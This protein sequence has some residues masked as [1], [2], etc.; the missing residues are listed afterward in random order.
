MHLMPPLR[1]VTVPADRASAS[2]VSFAASAAARS[3]CARTSAGRSSCDIYQG[4]MK[5]HPAI[6]LAMSMLVNTGSPHNKMSCLG[7]LRITR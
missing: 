1:C 6:R 4:Q 2:A 3:A 5:R 7:P